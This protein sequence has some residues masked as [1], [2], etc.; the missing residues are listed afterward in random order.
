MDNKPFLIKSFAF[1]LLSTS[2]FSLLD[3]QNNNNYHLDV[4]IMRTLYA[5]KNKNLSLKSRILVTEYDYNI[6]DNYYNDGNNYNNFEGLHAMAGKNMYKSKNEKSLL[7]SIVK[8]FNKCDK[9]YEESVMKVLSRNDGHGRSKNNSS[10]LVSILIISAPIMLAFIF[11]ILC[12]IVIPVEKS[13]RLGL[14]FV[15]F[16]L[17]FVYTWKK[18]RNCYSKRSNN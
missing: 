2:F 9:T 14:S 8:C 5:E 3:N 6:Y 4:N 12:S 15:F 10:P 11:I 7:K 18:W 13:T 16:L 1:T 17:S